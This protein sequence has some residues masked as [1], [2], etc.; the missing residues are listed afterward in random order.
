VAGRI[1]GEIGDAD[2]EWH[3]VGEY[4]EENGTGTVEIRELDPAAVEEWS[5]KSYV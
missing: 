1:L 2:T 4:Q 3:S 5:R